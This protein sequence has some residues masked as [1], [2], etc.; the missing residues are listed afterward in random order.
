MGRFQSTQR[1]PCL[2]DLVKAYKGRFCVN[3]WIHLPGF[4]SAY[5][6]VCKRYIQ[7]QY[8]DVI[9]LANLA[10][11]SPGKG[12]FKGIVKHIQ[13]TY[14]AFVVHVESVLSSQFQE[15]LLRMGFQN[16]GFPNNFYLPKESKE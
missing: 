7:G 5:V 2:D 8:M 1:T 15:G 11:I 13:T 16:T 9:D 12:A 4:R 14:P 10:A 3:E 6:R